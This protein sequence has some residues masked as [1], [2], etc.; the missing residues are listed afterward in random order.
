MPHYLYKDAQSSADYI[1][2]IED[3]NLFMK[4]AKGNWSPCFEFIDSRTVRAHPFI[5]EVLLQDSERLWSMDE[6]LAGLTSQKKP[7]K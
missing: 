4:D 3:K 7:K 6:V 2:I 5:I 1:T